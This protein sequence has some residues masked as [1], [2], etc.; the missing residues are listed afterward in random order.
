MPGP[1]IRD[2]LD[3]KKYIGF[4]TGVEFLEKN[5]KKR[6]EQQSKISKL[7]SNLSLDFN[8]NWQVMKGKL[9]NI[10]LDG[11]DIDGNKPARLRLEK[12]RYVAMNYDIHNWDFQGGLGYSN[13]TGKD[14]KVEAIKRCF[15][16]QRGHAFLYLLTLNVRHNLKEEP[17]EYLLAKAKELKQNDKILEWY[18]LNSTKGMDHYR[19]KAVVPLFVRET[20]QQSGHDCLVYPPL[21]YRGPKEHLLHFVFRLKPTKKILTAN[22]SQEISEVINLPLIKVDG[23]KFIFPT[24]HP[25]FDKREAIN[26]LKSYNL[27]CPA[28]RS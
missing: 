4:I 17:K 9:E 27:P 13:N 21:Y 18:A 20:A 3:W 25:D 12:N 8:G 5:G 2:L 22:S 7:M 26:L 6:A 15:Q 1:D 23:G 24:Q 19:T 10:I 28:I 14:D 11:T 16:L